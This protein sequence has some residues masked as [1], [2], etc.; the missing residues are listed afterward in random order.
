MQSMRSRRNK[1]LLTPGMHIPVM[2]RTVAEKQLPDV[3][4]LLAWNYADRILEKEA[5][6]KKRGGAFVMPIGDIA[7]I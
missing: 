5:A 2:C 4:L 6:F 3:F 7:L 1:D